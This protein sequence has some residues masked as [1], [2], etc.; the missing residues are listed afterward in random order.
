MGQLSRSMP[1]RSVKRAVPEIPAAGLAVLVVDE[2]GLAHGEHPV[3][4]C[5]VNELSE[6]D[7]ADASGGVYDTR[8][9]ELGIDR[10]KI[11]LDPG[12]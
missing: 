12:A 9:G 7:G 4:Q 6:R 2:L 1:A 5:V 8:L 3:E 11:P 10:E